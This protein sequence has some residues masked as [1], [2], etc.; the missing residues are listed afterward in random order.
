MTLRMGSSRTAVLI[1]NGQEVEVM[2]QTDSKTYYTLMNKDEPVLAFFCQRNEFDEPVFEEIEWH[3]EYCP[4]GYCELGSFL[5]QRKAP[6]HRKHIQQLLSQY[7]CDDIEGFLRVT[8]ALS[9]NDTFWVRESGSFLSWADVSLYTNTFSEI[10]SEAAFDGTISETD[11]SSTLPEF[12]TDGYYAKCW[13]READQ[14]YLYK[15]GSAHYEIEPLSEYLA[16][17]IAVEICPDAIHYDMGYHHDKLISKCPLFTNEDVGLAKASA[18]FRGKE[19]TI[20]ELLS[21]F[22]QIGSE[23]AFR[24]MCILDAIIVNPDRHYGNFGLLFNTATMDVLE[25][26]PVFDHN[27]SLFP[28]LD[29]EQLSN[30]DWYL[31]HC[32]PRL[33]KDFLI[34]ARGL[35]TD[36]IRKDLERLQCFSFR[37]HPTIPV[38]QNLLKALTKLVQKQISCIL[39]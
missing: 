38:D 24:R 16:S 34:T 7:G 12:G 27:R 35:L 10:I 30:P 33:G 31:K 3:T 1:E 11:F 39:K 13:V 23:D 29:E 19:H 5:E 28:E 36:S 21:Y 18:I 4:I 22:T 20:P 9:L 17:Q 15:S 32:R 6:K 8:H 26:A 25:M 2:R 14:I 37:Q